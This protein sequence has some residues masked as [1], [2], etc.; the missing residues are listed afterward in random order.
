MMTTAT[1][2]VGHYHGLLLRSINANMLT[3]AMCSAGL[4]T[5]HEETIISSGHSGHNRSLLLLEHVRHMDMQ[6]LE[7]FCELVQEMW[8]QIGSQLVTGMCINVK[9]NIYIYTHM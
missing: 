6:A 7:I 5:V 9:K 3:D 4:L 2:L 8:P 1:L